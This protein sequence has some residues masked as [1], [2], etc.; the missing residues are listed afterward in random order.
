ML[1]LQVANPFRNMHLYT[2]RP[3]QINKTPYH[4]KALFVCYLYN[5]LDIK[6]GDDFFCVGD[7]WY[8]IGGVQSIKDC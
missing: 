4:K 7:V 8:A 2:M 1:T 6:F 3:L 5:D